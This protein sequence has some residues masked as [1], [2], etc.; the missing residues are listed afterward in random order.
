VGSV[1]KFEIDLESLTEFEKKKL[2]AHKSLYKNMF[3][4]TLVEDYEEI[5]FLRDY[6]FNLQDNYQRLNESVY[7]TNYQ[8]RN[9]T[10]SPSKYTSRNSA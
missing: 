4:V 5:F 3:E 6:E 10:P 1:K 2:T 9:Q 7:N 8:S